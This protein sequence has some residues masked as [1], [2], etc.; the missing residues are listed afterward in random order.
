LTIPT[1][2]SLDDVK[3]RIDTI[4]TSPVDTEQPIVNLTTIIRTV[5]DIAVTRTTD[6]RTLKIIG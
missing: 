6:E 4:D 1:A 2:K 5:L 3:S